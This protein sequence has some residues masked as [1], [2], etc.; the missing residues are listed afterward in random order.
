MDWSRSRADSRDH[1]PAGIQQPSSCLLVGDEHVSGVEPKLALK[2][3][4]GTAKQIGDLVGGLPLERRHA[5]QG[6]M[7]GGGLCRGGPDAFDVVVQRPPGCPGPAG[8]LAQQLGQ[9]GAKPLERGLDVDTS[10]CG[11]ASIRT[12]GTKTR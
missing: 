11:R 7:R 4:R 2:H 9:L 8:R 5:D 10:A 12:T 6:R 3:A 1:L